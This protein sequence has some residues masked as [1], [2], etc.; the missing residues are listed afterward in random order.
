MP[1]HVWVDQSACEME[2]NLAVTGAA[3]SAPKGSGAAAY[4]VPNGVVALAL[5]TVDA[6]LGTGLGNACACDGI[7]GEASVTAARAVVHVAIAVAPA[8]LGHHREHELLC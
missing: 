6:R 2:T 1:E 3:V 5:A 4:N 7:G 8:R